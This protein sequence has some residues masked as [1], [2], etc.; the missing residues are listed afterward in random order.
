MSGIPEAID[1]SDTW[2]TASELDAIEQRMNGEDV[3]RLCRA[4]RNFREKLGLA[5]A[6][7]REPNTMRRYLSPA[8]AASVRAGMVFRQWESDPPLFVVRVVG[9]VPGVADDGLLLAVDL[10]HATVLE[11]SAADEAQSSH[12]ALFRAG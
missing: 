7:R 4:I 6:P 8:H 2:I 11:T 1:P 12:R 9:F 10:R 3:P 5:S